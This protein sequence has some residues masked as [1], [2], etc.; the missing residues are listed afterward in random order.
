M[1]APIPRKR[2]LADMQHA[3]SAMPTEYNDEDY[4]YEVLHFEAGQTEALFDEQLAHEAEK[5]GRTISRPPT[6]QGQNENHNSVCESALTE[7]SHHARTASS[8]SAGSVS[9]GMTSRSSN[10]LP[11]NSIPLHARI[12][13]ISR[14]SLSFSEYEKY[15]AQHEAQEAMKSGVVPLPIPAE[16]A[17]SLFS[18][19]TRRSYVGFKHGIKS[20][21]KLR[22][23]K[24]SQEDSK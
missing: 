18:V 4:F 9:T 13:P 5:L 20:K 19:S 24:T 2:S 22:R 21:F 17:P 23:R 7:P 3:D 6:A 10:E 11:D 1:I 14:R 12:R 15:L 8:G 16:R